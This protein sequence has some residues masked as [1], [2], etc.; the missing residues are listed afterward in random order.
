MINKAKKVRIWATRLSTRRNLRPK[1]EAVEVVSSLFHFCLWL[2]V[3]YGRDAKPD[4]GLTFNPH[5]LMD[6]GKAEKASLAERQEL[7]EQLKR[8][9]SCRVGA[10]ACC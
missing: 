4:P 9:G 1:L 8:G 3:T 2:A 10:A 7:E 5:G 6:H